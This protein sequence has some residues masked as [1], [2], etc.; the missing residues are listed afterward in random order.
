MIVYAPQAAHAAAPV[1]TAIAEHAVSGRTFRTHTTGGPPIELLVVSGQG[2][3]LELQTPAQPVREHF[4]WDSL[5]L[6]REFIRLEQKVLAGKAT[7]EEFQHYDM[8]KQD[9][10]SEIFADRYLRDYAEVQRLR[11]LNEKLAE[12]QQYLRPVRL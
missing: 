7:D 9:R 6:N 1:A 4:N 5:R 10:N 11:K 12:L 2:D 8:M 3:A